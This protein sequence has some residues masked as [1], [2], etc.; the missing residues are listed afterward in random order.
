M[1]LDISMQRA[2]VTQ[3]LPG[4]E[5]QQGQ[6]LPPAVLCFQTMELRDLHSVQTCKCHQTGFYPRHVRVE[7]YSLLTHPSGSIRPVNVPLA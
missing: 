3:S 6:S 4:L 1:R 7:A 2:S 5:V